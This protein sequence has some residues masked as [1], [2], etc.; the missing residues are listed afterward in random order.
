[1]VRHALDRAESL[2]GI[3]KVELETALPELPSV[4]ETDIFLELENAPDQKS[5]ASNS[6]KY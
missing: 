5:T 2:K 6:S 1:M 4:P 3:K